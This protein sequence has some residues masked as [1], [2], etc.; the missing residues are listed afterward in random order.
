LVPA[1]EGEPCEVEVAVVERS[2][3]LHLD[4]AVGAAPADQLPG[5]QS[6]E[7]GGVSQSE[8]ERAVPYEFGVRAAIR[9]ARRS[10]IESHTV[11]VASASRTSV[12]SSRRQR[13]R[14]GDDQQ[15]GESEEADNAT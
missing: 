6:V 7:P 12:R 10:A 3:G 9:A 14:S 15:R 1:D 5:G 8:L 2:I 11:I 13:Q 4:L